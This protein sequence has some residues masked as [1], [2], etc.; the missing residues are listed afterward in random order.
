[1]L[2]LQAP[3]IG[4]DPK[5]SNKKPKD[6]TTDLEDRAF[7]PLQVPPEL[8]DSAH[9]AFQLLYGN[10]LNGAEK[11][12]DRHAAALKKLL[13]KHDLAIANS[14]LGTFA[15]ANLSKELPGTQTKIVRKALI[16][17]GMNRHKAKIS[18]TKIIKHAASKAFRGFGLVA[19][20]AS[21]A[22]LMYSWTNEDSQQE[23]EGL[24][25]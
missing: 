6:Q 20:I 11:M 16:S 9:E 2:L 8:E 18:A 3:A 14:S 25:F 12:E 23:D 5:N 15:F 22:N 21:G 10:S 7:E 24:F 4:A 13:K 19:V 17:M 1:M